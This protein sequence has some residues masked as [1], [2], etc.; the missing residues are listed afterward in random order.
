[1][2]YFTNPNEKETKRKNQKHHVDV[3]KHLHNFPTKNY[4]T[5]HFFTDYFYQ[6]H[7]SIYF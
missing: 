7:P 3:I 6:I 1:M 4:L 5:K 2:Q